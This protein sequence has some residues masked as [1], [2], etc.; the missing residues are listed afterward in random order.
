V[1]YFIRSGDFVKIGHCV[2]D[3]IRRLGKLQVGNPMTLEL[4]AMADG[5][6]EEERN[7]HARFRT[8]HVRGEWFR[9]D[10]PLRKA[11]KRHA[12]DHDEWSRNRPA[13]MMEGVPAWK[14]EAYLERV[15]RLTSSIS[16]E[17]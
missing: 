2:R 6:R 8:L 1:I 16:K 17:R 12:V 4:I 5:D 13:R 3:P 11:I 10:E 7:W 14:V 15:T 9:L